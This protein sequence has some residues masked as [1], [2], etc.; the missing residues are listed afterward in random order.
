[1]VG[2]SSMA[3]VAPPVIVTVVGA[4]P[5]MKLPESVTVTVT[6]RFPTG[7]ESAPVGNLTVTVTVTDSGNF[8]AG[9][10]PT[11]VTITGG[12]T[13][14][15]LEVPTMAD[16]INE[17][18]GMITATVETG[19]GYTVDATNNSASV[20]VND[21]DALPTLAIDSPSVAEGDAGSTT[22]SY[23]VTLTG[24]TEQEVTVDY[25]DAGVAGGGT[26]TSGA[27][28]TAITAGT[29]TFAP[30]TTTQNIDVT[31]M[32][33]TMDEPNET[34]FVTLSNPGNATI[35][36]GRGTGTGTIT[37]DDD[38]VISIAA[39][40]AV[41]EGTPATFTVTATSA[42]MTNLIVMV[43]VDDG[44]GNFISSP[45]PTT[46]TI[47][48]STTTATLMV[49]TT[50]DN[51]DEANGMITAT[52][53]IGTGYTVASPPSNSASV[54]VNDND[55]PPTL[56]I[57]SPSVT[58]GD[59]GTATLSYMVTLTGDTAQTVMVDYADAGSGTAASGADYETITAGT[60]TF[61]PGGATTQT[62]DVTVTG[63]T[64]DEEDETVIVT[65]SGAVNAE[66]T[67][68]DG[69]GTIDDDDAEPTL[70]IDSP[71]VDEGDSGTATLRYTVTLTGATEKTVMVGYAGSGGTA[72][73]G[74]DYTAITVGTLTFAPGTT[75]QTIDV[76][77][78][79]DTI[80]EPNETV[81]VTL[82]S[83]VNATIES[84]RGTGTGTIIN[85]DALVPSAVLAAVT[86]L[87]EGNLNRPTDTVTVT[88][89]LMN[90]MYMPEAEL[91][92]T[93][94]RLMDTVAGDVT[95]S[96][97]TR[98]SDVIATLRLTHSGED[99]APDGELSVTVLASAHTGSGD[100]PAGSVPIDAIPPLV[101]G[102]GF[103]TTGPY[104]LGAIIEVTFTFAA[105]GR[106]VLENVFVTGSPNA[107]L[108]I[109]GSERN[110]AYNRGSGTSSLI[111]RYTVMAGDNDADGVSLTSNALL[112][113]GGLIRDAAG[114]NALRGSSPISD[115]ATQRV[116]GVVPILSTAI[117]DGVT[118]VLTY[119]EALGTTS[120][121]ANDAYTVMVG[122]SAGP[123]VNDVTISGMAVTLMLATAI[124]GGQTVTLD[125]T[126]GSAPVQDTVGNDA[127]MLDD[128][129]VMNEATPAG[130]T[131]TP[132]VRMVDE[133][134]GMA[135]YTVAL[136]TRPS[137][138]VRITPA[139]SDTL[140]ATTSPISLLFTPFDWNTA[141]TVTVT[142]VNDVM[143]NPGDARTVT[144]THTAVSTDDAYNGGAIT[145][146]PVTVTVEDDDD[147]ISGTVPVG[148]NADIAGDDIVNIAEKANGFRISGTVASGA[149]VSV[150]IG[151]GAARNAIEAGPLWILDIPVNAPEITGASV[152]VVVTAT[153]GGNTGT[154]TRSLTVDLMA[155]MASYT[156]PGM[157]T[158]GTTITAIMPDSPSADIASYA[159]DGTLPPG[160]T[161]N[162]SDGVISGTPTTANSAMADVTI[163]LTDTG[164][165]P[166]NVSITF[167]AVAREPL[168]SA[169]LFRFNNNDLGKENL[170]G[171]QVFVGLSGVIYVPGAQL[172]INDFM[173]TD[174]I[175]GEVTVSDVART[176]DTFATLTL[177][178]SGEEITSDGELSVTVLASAHTGSGDLPA[179]S[180]PIRAIGPTI[181][182][183]AFSTMGPYGPGADIEVTFTFSRN[184]LVIEIPNA[185][186][187]IGGSERNAVYNGSRLF[188]STLV[189]RYTV[190]AG[191]DDADGVD[192][193]SNALRGGGG[194]IRDAA[195]NN[196]VRDSLSIS[197]G[198]DQRVATLPMLSTATVD[199]DILVL[200]YNEALDRASTP[201]NDAYAVM[202]G[203]S[204]GPAVNNVTISGRAVTLTLA[205]A[206]T[207]GQAV[208]LNYTPGANPVQ[209]TAGN[210]AAALS[211][212]VVT[213]TTTTTGSVM[214]G[215][216]TIAT[217]NI[218]NIAEKAAGFTISGTVADGAIV[219]VTLDSGA[220]RGTTETGTTWTLD[221]PPDDTEI[222]GAS[223][224]VEATATLSGGGTGTVTRP[225]T[226]DLVAPT[227]GYT[228][229]TL[230]VGT[231]ITAITPDTPSSDIVGY[232]VQTGTLPPG[233]TLDGTSG[234]ISG[235]PTTANASTALVMIRLTD[236][237]SNTGDVAITFPTVAMGSQ[238]LTDF[239]YNPATVALN[240]PTPP[241]VMPP[242]GAQT[243][244][245]LSY[246]SGDT[247]V[248]TVDSNT[249]ALT[250]V[251]AGTCVITV[252]ASATAN[253]NE[254][255]ATFTITVEPPPSARLFV[256]N[257][258]ELGKENLNGFR[259]F[260]ELSGVRYV[261]GAQ[262]DMNDFMLTDD[263]AG[264]VTVSD[265]AR[266]SDRVVALTLTHSGEDITSDGELS[267]TVLA[268]AHTGSGDLPAGS[269][270]IRAIGPTIIGTAFSTMGPYGP[271]ANIEVTFTFSRNVLVIGIPNALLNIGGSER[272]AVYNRG[273]L[274]TS[275]LVFR[276]TVMAGDDDADGV[277]IP[278]NALR[279]GGGLIRDAA[280]NNAVRDSLSISGGADQRVDT[281]G[282]MLQT[283][284]VNGNILTLGYDEALD[285]ASAPANGAYTVM[286][287]S[288]A[289]P[290]VTGVTL[291]GM[292]VT[293]MLATAVPG[294]QIV[295]L[296]YTPGSTPLQDVLGNDAGALNGQA[297]TSTAGSVMVGLNTI[298]TD[299][300]VNIAEKATGFTISGTVEDGAT[301]NVTIGNGMARGT[302]EAGATWTLDIPP[303]DTEITGTSVNVVVT[304]TM[305]SN[306][307]TVTR[308]LTV[309]LAAPTAG[310]TPP[311]TLTVGT[312]ITAITPDTPSADVAGYIVQ[313]GI[314][315]PGLTLD[316]TSG[317]ISG[318][319]TTANAST[320]LVMI[321]LTDTASNTGDVTITFP[322]VAM[323]SQTLEGFAYSPGTVTVGQP[324][325][326]VPTVTA[327]TGAVAGSTLSYSTVSTGI[328]TVDPGT[329]ALMLV[330]AGDC[331]IR[332]IASATANYDEASVDFT[333]TVAVL[334][335]AR[336]LL[337]VVGG[338]GKENLDGSS[339]FVQLFGF[340][341]V[342]GAQLDRNDFMLTDDIAGE[343]TVF[344]VTRI[345]ARTATLRLTHSGE[346]I[347]SDGE[348]SVTVLASAHTGSVNLPAGSVQIDATAP[349]ITGVAFRTT[350]PYGPG[351]NIEV[352]FTFSDTAFVPADPNALLNIGGSERNAAY[353]RGRFTNTLVFRYTVMA[354]DNDADG[355]DIPSNALRGGGGLIRDIA[356]N[357]AVR[358]SL[359][360]SGGADQRVDTTGPML[361]TAAVNG[362][363]LTLGYDEAL[364]TASAPAN[365]AYT[366]M[367]GSSAGPAVTG[368]TL[369]GMDVT[370]ML[371]TAVPGGQIVTLDYTPGSTP[372]QDVLG[373]DAGVL[374]GQAVTST[375]GSVMV[376][377]DTI[378][379]DNIVNIAEKAGGFTISGTV[380]TG[381]TVSVIIRGG[382]A[383]LATVT[384]STWTLAIPS[385]DSD[386][387]G[388]SVN[389]VV[390]ATIGS[391]TGTVTRLLD[392]NLDVPTAFYT[393][394]ASL[395]V[396][397]AIT[398]IRPGGPADIVSYAVVSGDLPPGLMLDGGSGVI[399]GAPTTVNAATPTVTIQLTDIAGNAG[400]MSFTFPAVTKG[401]QTL[402]GFSYTP[403]TVSDTTTLPTVTPPS[404]ARTP[405]SY[406][407]T[408]TGICTV[409]PDTGALMLVGT[410]G[411]CIIT[412]TASAT[413][414]Y[415]E[416]TADFT[417]TVM[418]PPPPPSAV[419]AAPTALT[420]ATL[421]GAIVTVTLM[422]T[423][424]VLPPGSADFM[425]M[426]TVE[427]EVTVESVTRNSAGTVA[428]LFLAHG[429]E[430]ISADGTLSV[431]VRSSAH[432]LGGDLP[433]GEVLITAPPMLQTAT[434][435][436]ATL[437]LRYDKD[438]DGSSV[439]S[440]T[441]YTVR[442]NSGTAPD[443]SGVAISG[444][445]VLLML[446]PQITP[447]QVVRLDYTPGASPVQ[448]AAG[449]PAA[450]LIGQNVSNIS[451]SGPVSLSLATIA[452]DNIVNIAEKGA[453]FAI[454]G[455]VAAGALLVSVEVGGVAR[456]ATVTGTDWMVTIPPN[457][458][459]ISGTSVDVVVHATL[460]SDTGTVTRPLVVDLVRP[461]ATYT[462]PQTSLVVG[463]AITDI[464][465]VNPSADIATYAVGGPSS[466][467][468]GTS[469]L[470]PLG[471]RLDKNTG[472]ISGAPTS[473]SIFTVLTALILLTDTAGN[474][475]NVMVTFPTVVFPPLA[476]VEATR[477]S[478]SRLTTSGGEEVSVTL[479]GTSNVYI[480]A[481]RVADFSLVDTIDGDV[482]LLSVRR[483]SPTVATLVLG[484]SGGP[485]SAG[486]ELF[487]TVRTTAYAGLRELPAGSIPI[488]VTAVAGVAFSTTGPYSPGENIEARVTFNERVHVEGTTPTLRMDLGAGTIAMAY[489]R[490]S[491]TGSLVFR[492][493]VVA[494]DDDSDGVDIPSNAL[495]NGGGIIL[496]LGSNDAVRDSAPVSG[497]VN[498]RVDTITPVLETATVNGV[499]L[500]LGYNEA[501]DTS[502]TPANG[503]YRVEAGGTEVAAEVDINGMDVTLT[504]ATLVTDDQTVTLDYTPGAT[505]VQDEA[506]NDAAMLDNRPVMNNTVP[507]ISIVADSSPVT[508]GAV[509]AFT[510]TATPPPTGDMEVMLTVTD[511]AG[512]FI[513]DAAPTMIR[514]ADGAT[515][516]MLGVSTTDDSTDE[517]D[518]MVSATVEPG[519]GYTVAG[520]PNNSASVMV[521]DN[522]ADITVVLAATPALTE[523]NLNGAT[524]TATLVN[525]EYLASLDG[526]DFSVADDV[527]G[528]VRV[529]DVVR[530]STTVA[531]LTLEHDQEEIIEDGMLGVTV[532]ASAH[533]GSSDHPISDSV[534][535]AALNSDASLA[536]LM[537]SSASFDDPPLA[538]EFSAPTTGYMLDVPNTVAQVMVTPIANDATGATISVN[539]RSVDSGNAS[540]AIP[541]PAGSSSL[542][543]IELRAADR[544]R[545]RIYTL[546]VNRAG[547]VSSDATLSDLILFTQ[548]GTPIP[549]TFD[550]SVLSYTLSSPGVATSIRLEP[551]VNHLA[552]TFRVLDGTVVPPSG[553]QVSFNPRQTK[554]V[555]VE[556]TAEDG[557][558]QRRYVLEI[559]RLGI[560]PQ[561]Q[562]ANVRGG[563]LTLRYNDQLAPPL[564]SPT[565]FTV[566]ADG[567]RVNVDTVTLESD[568]AVLTLTLASEVINDQIVTLSYLPGANPLQDGEGDPVVALRNEAVANLT[569]FIIGPPRVVSAFF[570]NRNR[571]VVFF[572][573]PLYIPSGAETPALSDFTVTDSFGGPIQLTFLLRGIPATEHSRVIGVTIGG[574]L[575]LDLGTVS[576]TFVAPGLEYTVTYTPGTNPLRSLNIDGTPGP[577]AAG[578]TVS[579]I[580]R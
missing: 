222:T 181:I 441:A 295:T 204:T 475:R 484:H 379:T 177:T 18:N 150:T 161:L 253:Y 68:P 507:A 15:M 118:L 315:P 536:D 416:A 151:G 185:L 11:T 323:G 495:M 526:T 160:L 244:S 329:G 343:V 48:A 36:S 301:V 350:G 527:P 240:A 116:D 165:N 461:T 265:V 316:G 131:V 127:V 363:I 454:S 212:A 57:D 481:L 493:T 501:L 196:A 166:T 41:I 397:T 286:V 375:A 344:D 511:G 183:T 352:T 417:V 425:L 579:A 327:P 422:N 7:A 414:N 52:V 107:L 289:G 23:T 356:S 448:D 133:D 35:E 203:G 228:P 392:V 119:T 462:A 574:V 120:T 338:L 296:D 284:A 238:T 439:P 288:S 170:N 249:G 104:G 31:V 313:T 325:P 451:A 304:A 491:G 515:T 376:G 560:A 426:D 143:N 82:L 447:D 391:D 105:Q 20:T 28:Y 281:T 54:T 109:G 468:G 195:G 488:D 306:T 314:L 61:T 353:N 129:T 380:A 273:S 146:D 223:V 56:A 386:I 551:V 412:V 489:N 137:A 463:T 389:V 418:V 189:F 473:A 255:S 50:N 173:L 457:A 182:G 424:Y 167:P 19:A 399:S 440:T 533:T 369:S 130:V 362:N 72:A 215:L 141:Q 500:T 236:T 348:L 554:T 548:A 452:G 444:M 523:A 568:P 571:L 474:T 39:G 486:G 563:S 227:A 460:G 110:A 169:Q 453:G 476:F 512:V 74:T 200:T 577:A 430:N 201:A 90:T 211:G 276:Y 250:L 136:D 567:V 518:G 108:N 298:A 549:F 339:V 220:P 357:N 557:I 66:I 427:G 17:A 111:F 261:P 101:S 21:D 27:D 188:T 490:G 336:V 383:R 570:F 225:L 573:N 578:F 494:G 543:I 245:T 162:S 171:F 531:T 97:V 272:N 545:S 547:A 241:A 191:D 268:S 96:A 147:A 124:P 218:V 224:V 299:N 155:P 446:S 342:P 269:M 132:T 307:G 149:T 561:L 398:D 372:V 509:A 83:T 42:P 184:V 534:P 267:V 65:L 319:P 81:I 377:L 79:G 290:A 226:V 472:V 520:A 569:P 576:S 202:V 8:I 394:P 455:T 142:G 540:E 544:I 192:I 514:I 252:T 532:L 45:A 539:G 349:T 55:D 359:S 311:G 285:T 232:I 434:V 537:V 354:G 47:A 395:M 366:V 46:V 317:V 373:N 87:G 180:M 256:L 308:P 84:G 409:D 37:D 178:H 102:L 59:S 44:G 450:P 497:G 274:F 2:T 559:S 237:V 334:Q 449:N 277:D 3:V 219:E 187:N 30:G 16:S 89:T 1:M 34:V 435:D 6:V 402:T 92:M 529:S 436:D 384:G 396:G 260:V 365:G 10:A 347:T 159:M 122:G 206:V 230:T 535:V 209:D 279:G 135:T 524:V 77:V 419:L 85:D 367:V 459:E 368:V 521:E 333:V 364:D 331:I 575:S 158:V 86:P 257:N 546:Q 433:A 210:D 431:T 467:I 205:T 423:T 5:A 9:A 530:T 528:T 287:G 309:D 320:A 14:A 542:V 4:A 550:P 522:D 355:V 429:G 324:V 139:S 140:A 198:A 303:D 358:D 477:L 275:T 465:P 437:T 360:I 128:Q 516:A 291:S 428:T 208:T 480:E 156:P 80:D 378:A 456:A 153:L 504:L 270:P 239:A 26:A 346:E 148:L 231:A 297:V 207:S 263:I 76:T 483:T 43:T 51:T 264:E 266:S 164:G 294:G 370:L 464:V 438:L 555:T 445:D 371:A 175:A 235:A 322:T 49:S 126:P 387:T 71:R 95:V 498:Q 385:N 186:L 503:D 328:C 216:N 98:T 305:G 229:G 466:A 213:I 114:N 332:V 318:A 221:I 443:I 117:V 154:V 505:P 246:T 113:G 361:Q 393:P 420:E 293:L 106:G 564:P 517:S 94:F 168:P 403:D 432:V 243:G 411:E 29:L 310:Y 382:I 470:F 278:S 176:N 513:T 217:D 258:T 499:T 22:L 565:D 404:G 123:A 75:T 262:L 405:L 13:T 70:A 413:A 62:I 53:E 174:D 345:N 478:A 91:D 482:R 415:D 271:G 508:E 406:T 251:G 566:L 538:P 421:D 24:E 145:I 558:T 479:R 40:A 556:V 321:R 410:I 471:L 125:Y 442:V 248:C 100:L 259:V 144:V 326:T 485:I 134:G 179:G 138:D 330:A 73:S 496:D 12:A 247:D 58:E 63:D 506:G 199:G 99:I 469:S 103:S 312:A 525:T 341:Y 280:S 233:L 197:G 340:R 374:T 300:I 88:V 282:P 25:A 38:P 390:T 193:P 121:P 388:I 400:N 487:V 407:T 552:A 32:G 214:V 408:T 502:S 492:Y 69:T 115:G 381:A 172:G 337:P 242:S 335:S 157:L 541:V 194:L 510:L 351:A 283:A 78:M 60:L 292:D 190:M 64:I 580:S 112:G 302:T 562:S 401:S 458:D 33:D 254:A 519:S 553:D 152:D 572:D 93:D 163:R 234:V 67:T